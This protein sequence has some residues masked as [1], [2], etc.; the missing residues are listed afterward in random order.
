MFVSF[1]LNLNKKLKIIGEILQ[2][3]F[4]CNKENDENASI[5]FWL[6]LAAMM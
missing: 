6:S 4:F 1:K 3:I 2:I 5:K